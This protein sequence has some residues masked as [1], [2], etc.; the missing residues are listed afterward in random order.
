MESKKHRKQTEMETDPQIQRMYSGGQRG[1]AGAPSDMGD[2]SEAQAS[3]G[4]VTKFRAGPS[5]VTASCEDRGQLDSL[6]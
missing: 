3:R 1:E 5:I 2:G 4:K 6:P